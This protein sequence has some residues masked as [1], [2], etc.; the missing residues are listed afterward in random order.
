MRALELLFDQIESLERGL[1]IAIRTV[2]VVPNQVQDSALSK[3]ILVELRQSIPVVIPFEMR[4][5]V[6]LQVAWSEG[7]SIFSYKPPSSSEEKTRQEIIDLYRDL[8]NLVRE[9]V[10]GAPYGR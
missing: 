1:K 8:A 2:A 10:T 6:M 9:R 7:K 4:K 3:R 5:R